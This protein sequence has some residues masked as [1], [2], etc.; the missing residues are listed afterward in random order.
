MML[1]SWLAW[2][3]RGLVRS[4]AAAI[5]GAVLFGC[6]PRT[7]PESAMPLSQSD[8]EA[9]REL[10]PFDPAYL[11]NSEGRIVK[12]RLT[13]RHLTMAALKAVGKLTALEVLNLD[14]SDVADEGIAQLKDLPKLRH[15]GVSGTLITDEGFAGLANLKGLSSIYLF[16]NR[17]GVTD[18]GVAKLQAA[19]PQIQI[20]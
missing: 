18:A 19:R 5:A 11:L 9:V 1:F 15:L 12:L 13:D 8:A 4:V 3:S 17:G 20:N 10:D 16:N 14:R 7:V 2:R 6:Q